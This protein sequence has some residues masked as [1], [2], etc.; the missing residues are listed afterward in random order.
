MKRKL[1]TALI[2]VTLILMGALIIV[3]AAATDFRDVAEFT[4]D[5]TVTFYVFLASEYLLFFLLLVFASLVEQENMLLSEEREADVYDKKALSRG[6]LLVG[7]S[8]LVS[9]LFTVFGM[10]VRE[11][12]AEFWLLFTVIMAVGTVLPILLFVVNLL[13]LRH[14]TDSIKEKKATEVQ[15]YVYS[16]REYAEK[17]AETHL[18]KMKKIRVLSDIYAIVLAILTLATSFAIGVVGMEITVVFNLVAVITLV[19][20]LSRIRALRP[21]TTLRKTVY[22]VEPAEENT[23]NRYYIP[24]DKAYRAEVIYKPD[25]TPPVAV[26]VAIV[27]LLLLA[28]ALMAIIPDLIQMAKNAISSF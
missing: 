28:F 15:N 6:I 23:P 8:F 2:I 13:L 4:P 21:D 7:V 12:L 16:Q 25:G 26:I 9:I 22:L 5:E 1:Y 24:E 3:M 19:A 14:Y 11:A 27:V 10:L 20:S 18:A 17:S